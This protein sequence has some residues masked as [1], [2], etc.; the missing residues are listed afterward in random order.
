M[1]GPNPHLRLLTTYVVVATLLVSYLVFTQPSQTSETGLASH[2]S[3]V[4][5][6]IVK[7]RI[8]PK[9]TFPTRSSW[10][11]YGLQKPTPKPTPKPKPVV[12]AR[13]VVAERIAQVWPGDD[14][15]VIGLVFGSARCT[16]GES[17]GNPQ[18][19]GGGGNNY[20]GLY[21]FGPWARN[22]DGMGDPRGQTVEVQTQR[23]WSLIKVT[24]SSQWSCSPYP[25]NP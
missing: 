2:R 4:K 12:I 19:T 24:D 18:A 16:T 9:P 3:I 25:Y 23:A 14:R 6:V 7:V 5:P 21:Q 11:H 20:W 1:R 22:R 15:W 8:S 13:G 10:R 17:N